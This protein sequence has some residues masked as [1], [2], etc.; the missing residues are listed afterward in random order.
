MKEKKKLYYKNEKGR[1]VEYVEQEPP[2]DN[3]LFR[4][5]R[6]GSK[7]SYEPTSML[8]TSDLPEGVWVVMKHVYGKS[9]TNGMYLRD[10][11]MCQKASDIQD[12]SLSKLGGMD[13]L[14][15]WLLHNYD[16]IPQFISRYDLCRAIVGILF[17]YEN[18]GKEKENGKY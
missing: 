18:K 2:Y 12:V 1:Y 13:K 5:V 4:R 17:D 15:D 10:M 6:H 14:A 11:F 9:V 7:Y 16:K 3:A 8:L